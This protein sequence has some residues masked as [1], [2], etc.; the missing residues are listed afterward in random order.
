MDDSVENYPNLD[1]GLSIFLDLK[2]ECDVK[3]THFTFLS[4]KPVA[5]GI[6]LALFRPQGRSFTMVSESYLI[7]W[8]VSL[9]KWN[10]W[11]IPQPFQARSGD[12]IGIFYDRKTVQ[13]NEPV[14]RSKMNITAGQNDRN[15]LVFLVDAEELATR[16]CKFE[17][18]A[19]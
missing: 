12:V 18:F 15:T 8:P 19:A 7:H 6:H 3:V 2:I 14:V 9:E 5:A 11:R 10:H 13:A 4:A 16:D 17:L 1:M